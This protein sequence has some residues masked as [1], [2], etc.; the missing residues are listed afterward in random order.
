MHLKATDKSANAADDST[1]YHADRGEALDQR[2]GSYPSEE[3]PHAP[4]SCGFAC[5]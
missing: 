4:K 2:L 1:G 3:R 5:K